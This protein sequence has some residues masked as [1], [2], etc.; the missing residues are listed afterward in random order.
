MRNL[1]YG[2]F[3]GLSAGGAMAMLLNVSREKVINTLVFLALTLGVF[4]GFGAYSKARYPYQLLHRPLQL[5]HL[6]M[7]LFLCLQNWKGWISISN[8]MKKS[9]PSLPIVFRVMKI[10]RIRTARQL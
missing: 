9:K 7:Y 4:Y 1:A 10:P 6:P 3:R 8:Q 2:F 5:L